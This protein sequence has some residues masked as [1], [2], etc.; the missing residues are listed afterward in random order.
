MYIISKKKDYYDGVVGTTGIDKTVV[1]N[2]EIEIIEDNSKFPKEFNPHN[3]FYKRSK[4]HLVNGGYYDCELE[5]IYHQN[6]MF[7]VGFCGKL[8]IGWKF[9]R[10]EKV[11]PFG[12]RNLETHITYDRDFIKKNLKPNNWRDKLMDDLNFIDTY[13]SMHIFRH[14][15]VPIFLYDEDY[16]RTSIDNRAPRRKSVF[17]INPILGDYEFYKIFES[18]TAFQEVH[19][20]MG[21]VLGSG[22]KEIVEVADK[23]KI[24]Q[25]GFDKWSFRKEPKEK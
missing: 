19:M 6:S 8:Y 4:R 25:H 15:K 5:S 11:Q 14:L 1:Y 24:G 13:D 16:K 9:Y 10:E 12:I 7:I 23:Y 20:F 3:M 18:F 2:R 21:G 22:E 17:I